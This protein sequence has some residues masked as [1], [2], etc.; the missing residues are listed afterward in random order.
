M[1]CNID[2]KRP[3]LQAIIVCPTVQL[4]RQVARVLEELGRRCAHA[5]R[6]NG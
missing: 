1:L 4:S 2:R 3:Q 5:L 6:L